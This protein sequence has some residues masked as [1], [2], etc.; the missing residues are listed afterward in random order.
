MLSGAVVNR[1]ARGLLAYAKAN[2]AVDEIDA[3]F[4]AIGHVV[5]NLPS[6]RQLLANPV[7]ST[8]AKLSTIDQALG[9]AFRPDLRRFLAL[10]LDRGRGAYVAAVAARFHELVDEEHG[11]IEVDIEAAQPLTAEQTEKIVSTLAK[12]FGKEIVP[13]VRQN[14]DLIAGCRVQVGNRVLDATT[15]SALRQ[16]RESLLG[17]A[18]RKEGTR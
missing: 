4:R 12:A 16:F 5:E 2:G 14:T 1:Y 10:L 18:L 7:L 15:Q 17:R 6:F 11:R 8:E 9:G 3:Q 13:N